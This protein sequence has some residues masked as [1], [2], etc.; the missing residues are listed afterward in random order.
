MQSAWGVPGHFSGKNPASVAAGDPP[1]PPFIPPDPPDPSSPLFPVDFPSLSEA[2]TTPKSS[3]HFRFGSLPRSGTVPSAPSKGSNLTTAVVCEPSAVTTSSTACESEAQIMPPSTVADLKTAPV[4]ALAPARDH[5]MKENLVII[6]P[7]NISPFLTNKASSPV[8]LLPKPASSS[9][10]ETSQ[11][12]LPPSAPVPPITSQSAPSSLVQRLRLSEDKTLRRRAPVTIAPSGRPRVLIPDS[13]FHKG[14]E[15]HKDFIICYFNGRAPPFHMIQSVFNHLWG[16]GKRL[17]IHNNPLN[18]SVL[19]RIQSDYLR[20]KILEKNIWYVGESMF[21]TV[22][23]SSAH[24]K[25]TPP[26]KAIKIWAHLTGVPLDLRHEEG[27]SLV[28]G[29]IGDPKETDDFT[30]NLVSLTL[31]HVKVEVDLTK[32]LPSIVEFERED[33]EVVEVSVHYPWVPPTCSHCGELGHIVQNCL[34]YT[35]PPADNVAAKKKQAPNQSSVKKPVNQESAQQSKKYRPVSKASFALPSTSATPVVVDRVTDVIIDSTSLPSLT[36][37]ASASPSLNSPPLSLPPTLPLTRTVSSNP[38]L[39]PEPLPR[40]SLKRSRSSPSL[41]PPL[42][43]VPNP[44]PNP[45]SSLA[46]NT[47]FSLP[48]VPNPVNLPAPDPSSSRS[49][50]TRGSSFPSEDLSLLS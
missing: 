19:V 39:T 45:F 9:S 26:L 4:T 30:K 38:F 24:S 47:S 43:T 13:V 33:G 27:L 11:N 14:A 18:R 2:K 46:L 28:A 7:K 5:P 22:Q 48:P 25:T 32:P 35:P 36:V 31:A 16:K 37:A 8:P 49:F 44:N 50:G 17:E 20:Q 3:T 12:P 10:C 34:L 21:H 6:S 41:S 40:P 29:L 15:L 42:S 23:W 1:D